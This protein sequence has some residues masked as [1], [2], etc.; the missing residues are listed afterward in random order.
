MPEFRIDGRTYE[1]DEDGFMQEPELWNEEVAKDLARTEN[2]NEMTEEHWTLVRYIRSYY[3]QHG[4][5]PM[6]RKLSRETGFTPDKMYQ[7]FPSG[8]ALG[9]GKVAGLPK[10]HCAAR[11]SATNAGCGCCLICR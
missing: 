4:I 10:F 11:T 9:A 2:V 5:A 3:M 1:V 8:P 7:L 6:V